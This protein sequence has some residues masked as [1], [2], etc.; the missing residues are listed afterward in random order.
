MNHFFLT[1]TLSLFLGFSAMAQSPLPK[2]EVKRG[3]STTYYNQSD[4]IH[5]TGKVKSELRE[6][7]WEYFKYT[8]AGIKYVY[9]TL[10]YAAG[11]KSG[12]F[13]HYHGD[14]VEQGSYDFERLQGA[15]DHR[16][17]EVTASGDTLL[18]PVRRGAFSGGTM[19][20]K[21]QFFE[22]GKV[23]DAGAFAAGKKTGMWKHFHTDENVVHWSCEYEGGKKH[24][25][26]TRFFELSEDGKTKTELHSVYTYY[27]GTLAGEYVIKDNDGFEV[28]KGNY[29]DGK[30]NGEVFTYDRTEQIKCVSHYM[31]GDQSGPATFSNRADKVTIK[32]GFN[33]GKRNGKW[34]HFD[35]ESGEPQKEMTYVDGVLD[36]E[37]KAYHYNGND[38]ETRNIDKGDLKELIVFA[39]DGVTEIKSFAIELDQPQEGWVTISYT[40]N[41]GD[42]SE[43][44]TYEMQV[45]EELNPDNFV[46]TFNAAKVKQGQLHL[47]GTY[48]LYVASKLQMQGN[49]TK[50]K[51][52]GI[53]DFYYHPTVVWEVTY[54]SGK[55]SKE[56]FKTKESPEGYKGDFIVNFTSGKVQYEFKVKEGLRNGKCLT[57]D[58]DG[59]LLL[60]EKF[61]AGVL[62]E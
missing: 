16:H 51:K 61:K 39:T 1:V 45:S 60:E 14:T 5:F 44:M 41:H 62:V 24:G 50:D 12:P 20:G 6:G 32:G 59:M 9:R 54:A 33:K 53:W 55:K 19:V 10:T 13:K 29:I 21:W 37:W 48:E 49:Y 35:P 52:D 34:T 23:L 40:H 57:Y 38:Q 30:Q 4:T 25:K 22:A 18:V 58:A 31:D 43:Q 11:V 47:N 26:E 8:P 7:L 36:G 27:K 56:F 2:T 46:S 15:Y 42:S 17:Y 28:E 3:I